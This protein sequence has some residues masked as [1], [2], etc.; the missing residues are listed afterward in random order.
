MQ[1]CPIR[2]HPNRPCPDRCEREPP[3]V[4][5]TRARE[6]QATSLRAPR[7]VTVPPLTALEGASVP[8]GAPCGQQKWDSDAWLARLV[9]PGGERTIRLG[10]QL[11]ASAGPRR[12]PRPLQQGAPGVTGL[13]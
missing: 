9:V 5:V 7:V 12:R 2:V 6:C 4:H 1:L 3:P 10:S 13:P 8:A 11:T